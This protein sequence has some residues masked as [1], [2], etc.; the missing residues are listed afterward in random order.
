VWETRR[1]LRHLTDVLG[2]AAGEAK[3]E[4]GDA[5]IRAVRHFLWYL[6]YQTTGGRRAHRHSRPAGLHPP[7]ASNEP[8]ARAREARKAVGRGA[9]QRNPADGRH[10]RRY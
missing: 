8:N 9:N 2:A 4:G 1:I 3:A 6:E 5:M 10:S 7:L